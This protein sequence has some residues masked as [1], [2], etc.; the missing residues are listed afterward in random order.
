MD[1]FVDSDYNS[2]DTAGQCV[3]MLWFCAKVAHFDPS[4]RIGFLISR[5]ARETE[6][7]AHF[8]FV[9]IFPTRIESTFLM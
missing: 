5:N 7:L 8:D 1:F 3:Q 2:T 9:W 6:K 4:S